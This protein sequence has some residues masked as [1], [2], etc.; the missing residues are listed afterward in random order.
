MKPRRLTYQ[1]KQHLT[2]KH[3]DA[4]QFLLIKEDNYSYVVQKKDKIG[5][6]YDKYT[7]FKN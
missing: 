4:T 6:E 3:L 7:F 5:T 1:Q 2:K